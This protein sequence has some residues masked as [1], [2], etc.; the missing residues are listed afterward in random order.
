MSSFSTIEGIQTASF[1]IGL[2][3]SK[4]NDFSIIYFKNSINISAVFTKNQFASLSIKDAK[5]KIKNNNIRLIAV[6]SGNANTCTGK[7]AKET[8]KKISHTLAL[9]FDISQASIILSF[10]G[11]IGIPF[12]WKSIIEQ[13]SKN[14][15]K[16]LLQPSN[17]YDSFGKGILTTDQWEKNKSTTLKLS[18]GQTI[19]ISACAKGAG[20]IYPNMATML[21]YIITDIHIK[22]N[23][24]DEVLKNAVDVSFNSISVDGDSSTNDS[25]FMIS[26]G[27]K[28][29]NYDRLSHQDQHKFNSELNRICLELGK[30]IV[31]DGEGAEKI[32]Q[33]RVYGA[34]KKSDAKKIGSSI[35]NSILFKTAIHGSDPNYG[36]ILMA[37]GNSGVK[38]NIK[39]I[40]IEFGKYI[41]FEDNQVNLNQLENCS[42]YLKNN[43]EIQ[44]NIKI[45]LGQESC[46]Y[47]TC[48]I[49][50]KYVKFNSDYTT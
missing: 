30:D 35:S 50:T 49:G 16:F 3:E 34:K 7:H 4:K 47:W 26:T 17:I 23:T 44:L 38:L 22:K 48:D 21:A 11:V 43:Q 6:F 28:K 24:L 2:K 10:T 1:K 31:R 14:S 18:T 45:G 46:L 12:P 8:I 42:K 9:V 19:N 37:M 25:V 33:V 13:V 27:S 41:I 20:M 5:S 32:I 36:R 15:S 29:I 40:S 39:D